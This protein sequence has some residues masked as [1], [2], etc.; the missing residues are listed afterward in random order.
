MQL[1]Q[2]IFECLYCCCSGFGDNCIHEF[3][4]P[5]DYCWQLHLH[6]KVD[7][8]FPKSQLELVARKIRSLFW[9]PKELKYCNWNLTDGKDIYM[10]QSSRKFF[11]FIEWKE[12]L[13]TCKFGNCYSCD[14][15]SNKNLSTRLFLALFGAFKV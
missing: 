12:D 13:E 8:F 10:F 11:G 1:A 14:I 9:N 15:I 5:Q 3:Y 7:T 4:D 6:C 2:N